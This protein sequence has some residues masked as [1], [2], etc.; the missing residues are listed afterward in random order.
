MEIGA[1][2]RL[3]KADPREAARRERRLGPE[4]LDAGTL[5]L[6]DEYKFARAIISQQ[7]KAQIDMEPEDEPHVE[8][9]A[10]AA[11]AVATPTS[12]CC[13]CPRDGSTLGRRLTQ[14][15]RADRRCRAAP[16][17]PWGGTR[18]ADARQRPP[19][20]S[21]HH[22]GP[23]AQQQHPHPHPTLLPPHPTP[24]LVRRGDDRLNVVR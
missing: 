3:A 21:R 20:A 10:T 7:I 8:R 12:R 4:S 6:H 15:A 2:T 18:P 17:G 16:G 24:T 23:P 13:C 9:H 5:S 22:R 11:A 1:T 14:P 19:G